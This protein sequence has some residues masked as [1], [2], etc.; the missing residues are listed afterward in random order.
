MKEVKV[1][2]DKI[3]TMEKE[4]NDKGEVSVFIKINMELIK[5]G[6]LN[7]LT[8]NELKILLAIVS[9]MDDRGQCFPSQETLA[10]L[11]GLAV[12]TVS[13]NVN[14]LIKK[15]VGRKTFLHRKLVGAGHKKVSVYSFPLLFEKNG[16]SDIE[17]R[18]TAPAVLELFTKKYEE[19][20]GMPYKPNYTID[21]PKIKKTLM[22]VFNDEQLRIIVDLTI[23]E[24]DKR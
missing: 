4:L 24:Y 9:F 13:L 18:L 3:F 19:H 11:T 5:R 23:D 16:K 8:G 14:S 2:N 6:L 1:M 17:E 20:Y 10:N 7:E 15:R 12:C 22:P 21:L